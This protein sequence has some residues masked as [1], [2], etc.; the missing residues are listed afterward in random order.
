MLN[1]NAQS[2]PLKATVSVSKTLLIWRLDRMAV[3]SFQ[4]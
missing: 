2:K 1:L 3:K 4:S